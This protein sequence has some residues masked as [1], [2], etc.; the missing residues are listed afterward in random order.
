MRAW[1]V[2][3]LPQQLPLPFQAC[4]QLLEATRPVLLGLAPR[5]PLEILGPRGW[6]TRAEVGTGILCLRGDPRGR[7][8][9]EGLQ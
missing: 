1:G 9:P 8:R 7:V 5:P 3:G 4:G 2:G 6:R